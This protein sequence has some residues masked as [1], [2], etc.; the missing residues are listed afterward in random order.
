MFDLGR[1]VEMDVEVGEEG[2]LFVVMF[3][4]FGF[5]FCLLLGMGSRDGGGVKECVFIVFYLV[6]F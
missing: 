6:M 3:L 2:V 5:E 4:G 1:V